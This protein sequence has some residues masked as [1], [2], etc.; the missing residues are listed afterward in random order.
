MLAL[1]AALA[2][3]ERVEALILADSAVYVQESM[4]SA[5][6]NSPQVQRLGP[7]LGRMIGGSEAFVRQTYLD[8]AALDDAR[9]GLTLIHTEVEN[10]DVAMWDYL[11]AWGTVPIDVAD[12]LAAV[13]Q[14]ALVLTGDGDTIVPPADSERLANDL[15]N[16][17]YAVLTNCGHVPQEECPPQFAEA[18]SPWLAQLKR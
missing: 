2:Y 10:W 15:P 7:L 13:T 6:M 17:T 11:Q 1:E 8:P 9:M 5:I 3:P 14:P 16:A 18:V 4:P 12:R